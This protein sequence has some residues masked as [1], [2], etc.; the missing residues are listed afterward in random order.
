MVDPAG[1]Q[2]KKTLK[3]RVQ[4]VLAKDDDDGSCSVLAAVD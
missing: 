4:D 2:R 1:L 3:E